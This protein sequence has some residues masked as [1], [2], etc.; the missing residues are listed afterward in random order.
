MY[1]LDMQQ[2]P[3]QVRMIGSGDKA[4]RRPV[5]PSVS[6]SFAPLFLRE[7]RTTA[8]NRSAAYRSPPNQEAFSDEEDGRAGRLGLCLPDVDAHA[9]LLRIPRRRRQ[10][11]RYLRGH[12]IQE[13]ARY[14]KCG[15][16]SLPSQGPELLRLPRL[17]LSVRG[18]VPLQDVSLRTG[19]VSAV[20]PHERSGS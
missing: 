15:V 19:R 4:D 20:V 12:R 17:E 9:L 10:R 11:R 6:S 3:R 7:G 1:Q 8:N 16:F 2:Q 18:D 14:R 5:T 13:Q